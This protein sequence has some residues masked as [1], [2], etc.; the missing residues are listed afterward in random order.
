MKIRA[1]PITLCMLFGVSPALPGGQ[2]RAGENPVPVTLKSMRDTCRPLLIFAPSDA[3][4]RVQTQLAIVAANADELH[5]RQ[6]IAVPLPLAGAGKPLVPALNSRDLGTM[7]AA[8]AGVARKRFHVAPAD[9]TVVLL[10]RDG[11][12]KL[13][14]RVPISYVTLRDTIDAMPMRQQEMRQP[15]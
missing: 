5:E 11:G 4:Q 6:V 14:S 12:E 1:L 2:N 3:D 13:R 7:S 9:F 10:G 8:E 15:K